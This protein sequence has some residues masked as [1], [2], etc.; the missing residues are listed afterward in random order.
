M[1]R[2]VRIWDPEK[3][4]ALSQDPKTK[5]LLSD[6]YGPESA[7][8]FDEIAEGARLQSA[9]GQSATP[10]V[11]RQ[12]QV[13]DEVAGNVGR[14]IGG[15]IAQYTPISSLVLTG[16]G[17]RYGV[18]TISKV[19]GSA[20]DVL[21]VDY[22]M[23]PKLAIAAMERFPINNLPVEGTMLERVMKQEKI[24]KDK[25]FLDIIK[26]NTK[27]RVVKGE[28]YFFEDDKMAANMPPS[29]SPVSGSSLSQVS[30][31]AP[32]PTG[33]T[34]QETLSGLSQL[35]MPLFANQGGYID[36]GSMN[37]S[38]PMEESGIFSITKKPKQIVG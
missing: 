29:R 5:K 22:L 15:Y 35:G 16:V 31:V 24:D 30:P 3:L 38:V 32:R 12:D 1:Q 4:I 25:Y 36:R 8:L 18:N 19:R 9:V 20:I 17:R 13:S 7:K 28:N 26:I 10:N 34:S 2:T 11:S 14:M 23:N 37:T 6:L 21:I 27:D 33:Q